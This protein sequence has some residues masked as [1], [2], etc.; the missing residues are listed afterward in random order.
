MA[1]TTEPPALDFP[2]V[3]FPTIFADG[4]QNLA[5]SPTVVKFYL[6]RFDPAFKDSNRS[7]LTPVIQVVMPVDSFAQTALFFQRALENLI[8]QNI[9]SQLQIE[10]IRRDVSNIGD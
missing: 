6:M 8:H 10:E 3:N 2:P 1:M 9:I 7:Q 4:V 5:H